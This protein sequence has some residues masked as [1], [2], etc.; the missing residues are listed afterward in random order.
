MADKKERRVLKDSDPGVIGPEQLDNW[1]GDAL[2]VFVHCGN[3][4]CDEWKGK[5]DGGSCEY[6]DFPIDSVPAHREIGAEFYLRRASFNNR[7]YNWFVPL[8]HGDLVQHGLKKYIF[9]D[10]TV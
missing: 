4:S 1:V 3:G 6:R 5:L 2:T 10:R 7:P 8:K 9:M